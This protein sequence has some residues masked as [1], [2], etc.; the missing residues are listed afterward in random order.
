MAASDVLATIICITIILAVVIYFIVK[1]CTLKRPWEPHVLDFFS[2]GCHRWHPEAS[3]ETFAVGNDKFLLQINRYR[4]DVIYL[5]YDIEIGKVPIHLEHGKLE[6]K[7]SA[8]KSLKLVYPNGHSCL[9]HDEGSD[10]WYVR[11]N[12][13]S[14]QIL[15]MKA[16]RGRCKVGPDGY[17]PGP[18][19]AYYMSHMVEEGKATQNSEI[20]EICISSSSFHGTDTGYIYHGWGRYLTPL[21]LKF[22]FHLE[23]G[24]GAVA[25]ISSETEEGFITYQS[26]TGARVNV[27]D[28]RLERKGN[29]VRIVS[30]ESNIESSFFNVYARGM[31]GYTSEIEIIH[32]GRILLGHVIGYAS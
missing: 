7:V 27:D 8:D 5:C 26:P 17:A 32:N 10:L 28:A 4:D 25:E 11:P 20:P 2:P 16:S 31:G 9:S 29:Q 19:A 15:T 12:P 24:I 1:F 14:D 3:N 22:Y 23:S 18:Y 13:S 30:P 21:S 6:T